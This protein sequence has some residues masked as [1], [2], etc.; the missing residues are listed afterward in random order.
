MKKLNLALV[1]VLVA[2]LLPI[3]PHT[4]ILEVDPGLGSSGVADPSIEVLGYVWRDPVV[5]VVINGRGVSKSLVIA[6]A[7]AFR[8]WNKAIEAFARGYG[9]QYLLKLKFEVTLAGVNASKDPDVVVSFEPVSVRALGVTRLY[10]VG[11]RLVYAEITIFLRVGERKLS[12]VDV[13]NVALHE[14]G[15]ALG[16]GHAS[17]PSCENGDEIMYKEYR[18]P[19]RKLAPTTLDLYALAVAYSWLGGGPQVTGS[20]TVSLP[21]GM[22]YRMLLYYRVTV[23]SEIGAVEG[24]GWYPAGAIAVIRVVSTVIE[25]GLTRYVFTGWTGDV[26]SAEPVLK[27]RVYKDITV[28]ATWKTQYWVDI[29]TTYSTVNASSGWYDE[30]AILVVTVTDKEVDHGNLT[31]RVIAGWL[32]NGELVKGATVRLEVNRPIEART[33][34]E[35]YYFVNISLGPGGG[36][37]AAWYARGSVITVRVNSTLVTVG[38]DVRLVFKGW[39]GVVNATAP[40]ITLI[41]NSPLSLSALWTPQYKVEFVATD[42]DGTTLPGDVVVRLEGAEGSLTVRREAWL[43]PGN[44]TLLSAYWGGLNLSVLARRISVSGPGEIRVTLSIIRATVIVIDPF[45]L[46]V[47]WSVVLFDEAVPR[48]H[49]ATYPPRPLLLPLGERA[50]VLEVAGFP[51]KALKVQAGRV[52]VVKSPVGVSSIAAL[53]A[54]LVIMAASAAPARARTTRA[55]QASSS[56]VTNLYRPATNVLPFEDEYPYEASE[57]EC[58]PERGVSEEVDG[59][60]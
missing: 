21:L 10:R 19:R 29:E 24:G 47:P 46:P 18:W 13:F 6:A 26:E 32:I 23:V 54:A 34:W 12:V 57:E 1:L 53:L 16:L 42:I 17:S 15:H 33:V 36:R 50:A 38:N 56:A 2:A 8:T 14:A 52:I 11:G 51:C 3:A 28:I 49:S 55:A 41:V 45:G 40:S 43:D 44:W 31:K 7:E 25:K 9:Y 48:E 30:G 59:E 4:I 39:T 20:R 27:F 58:E 35:T 37:I 5:T 22:E 60:F